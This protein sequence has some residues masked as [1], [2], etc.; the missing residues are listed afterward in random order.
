MVV[1]SSMDP[2]LQA[3][4]SPPFLTSTEQAG[5][6]FAS[7]APWQAAGEADASTGRALSSPSL[8]PGFRCG[9]LVRPWHF[10]TLG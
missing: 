3:G 8:S 6:G 1:S 9:T 7:L 5:A 2:P 10:S 4:L